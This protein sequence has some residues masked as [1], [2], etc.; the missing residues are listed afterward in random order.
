MKKSV[1]NIFSRISQTEIDN[2]TR[3]VKETIAFEITTAREKVFTTAD[4]WS[5]QRQGRTR[6]SRRFI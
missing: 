4:L 2:F 3:E 6:I 1:K 5:I